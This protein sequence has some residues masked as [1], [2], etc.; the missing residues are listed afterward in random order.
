MPS[1]TG[2]TSDICTGHRYE[3]VTQYQPIVRLADGRVA[4]ASNLDPIRTIAQQEVR[5][6]P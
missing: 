4:Y 2:A 6:A 1:T 3:L 5:L